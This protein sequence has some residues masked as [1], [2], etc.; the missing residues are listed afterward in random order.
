MVLKKLVSLCISMGCT[1]V[2]Q[3]VACWMEV[4]NQIQMYI[5]QL[6]KTLTTSTV[7]MHNIMTVMC[8]HGEACLNVQTTFLYYQINVHYV[9][10]VFFSH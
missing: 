5:H 2:L 6:C 8:I 9:N 1:V 4:S 10:Y 7:Y 3:C